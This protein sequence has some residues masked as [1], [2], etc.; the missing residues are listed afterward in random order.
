MNENPNANEA[1]PQSPRSERPLRDRSPYEG[2]DAE[3]LRELGR[4]E[5][6]RLRQIGSERIESLREL[7]VDLDRRIVDRVHEQ[8]Y[9]AL[10]VAFGAGVLTSTVLASKLGRLAILAAGGFLVKQILAERD[11][12]LD[13]EE[14]DIEGEG[15]DEPAGGDVPIGER[16]RIRRR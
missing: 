10:G 8:P 3:R 9:M 1:K 4:E 16:R 13:E 2:R 6:E 5:I 7:G 12:Y 11:T 15:G 14:E